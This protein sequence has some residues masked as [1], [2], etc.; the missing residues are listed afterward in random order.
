MVATAW[1]DGHRVLY[2]WQ[3][4]REDYL[5]D[6]LMNGR[7][8]CSQPSGFNDPWDCKPYFNTEILED[9]EENRR[10]VEWAVDCCRK[11]NKM[12]EDDIEHM[13]QTLLVDRVRAAELLIQMSGGMAAEIDRKYR[14]YCLC[15]EVDSVLMWSHYGKKHSGVC[16]EFSLRNVVFCGAQPCE[17]LDEFPRTLIYARD[18]AANLQMLLAKA[19]A[20][21]YEHEYRLITEERALGTAGV[22][23]LK[24]DSGF[25]D[26]PDGALTAVIVGCQGDY[27]GVRRLVGAHAPHVTVKRAVRM[28]NRYGLRIEG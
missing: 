11:A 12:S 22:D 21:E 19:R 24:T 16:L 26:P 18:A 20:R 25:L 3:E 15:P 17:Y 28:P 7:V 8:Y 14:V 6:I 5:A 2:H 1:S 27:E 13:R 9:P 10:H 23:T 4:F